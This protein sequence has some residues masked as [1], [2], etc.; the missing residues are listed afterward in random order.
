MTIEIRPPN[1]ALLMGGPLM[2]FHEQHPL[3]E[4]ISQVVPNTD[5]METYD[6]PEKFGLLL[7]D[8]SYVIAGQFALRFAD[9]N[10]F[11]NVGD[12]DDRQRQ[13][14]GLEWMEPF[15][16]PGLKRFARR[17]VRFGE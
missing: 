13:Q 7:M 17:D 5:G 4:N 14:C 2:E 8:Q 1:A 15:R 3:L 6:P 12:R 16:L 9:V 11:K 10:G